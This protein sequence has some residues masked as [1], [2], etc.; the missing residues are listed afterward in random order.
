MKI[1][2]VHLIF[3]KRDYYFGSIAAIFNNS[4]IKIDEQT[5]GITR[6]T[7][8]HS[9]IT[10]GEKVLTKRAIIQT[11]QLIKSKRQ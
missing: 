7:L 4:E 2:H 3:E 5:L 8:A 6:E 11:A 9:A 10:R 1:I